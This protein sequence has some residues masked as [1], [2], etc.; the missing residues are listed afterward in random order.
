MWSMLAA[1]LAAGNPASQPDA[2]AA[3]QS[4]VEQMKDSSPTDDVLWVRSFILEDA[5]YQQLI[6]PGFDALAASEGHKRTLSALAQLEPLTEQRNEL[7]RV[8]LHKRLQLEKEL[9]SGP[10][11]SLPIQSLQNSRLAQLQALFDCIFSVGLIAEDSED[12]K[13]FKAFSARKSKESKQ[14]DKAI[15]AEVG[16]NEAGVHKTPKK[17][18]KHGH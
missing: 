5:A 15:D 2:V 6:G 17:S 9:L 13:D 11:S 7:L 12:Y 16:D 18:R 1:I 10:I 4:T 8:H 14:F 3:F